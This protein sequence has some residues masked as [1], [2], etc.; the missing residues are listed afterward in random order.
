MVVVQEGTKMKDDI[1]AIAWAYKRAGLEVRLANTRERTLAGMPG[2]PQR[3]LG[4]T[5]G[6]LERRLGLKRRWDGSY[7]HRI[8]IPAKR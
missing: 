3:W 1:E 2:R 4:F 5:I 6:Q 7:G 8:P